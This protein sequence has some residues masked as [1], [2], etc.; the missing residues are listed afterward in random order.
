MDVFVMKPSKIYFNLLIVAVKAMSNTHK[1]TDTQ[2][3][4]HIQ[5]NKQKETK[6]SKWSYRPFFC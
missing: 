3:N 2:T 5:K 1:Y 6:I 4:T